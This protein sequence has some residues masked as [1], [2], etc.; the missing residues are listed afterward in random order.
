MLCI[1]HSNSFAEY[2][3]GKSYKINH[4]YLGCSYQTWFPGQFI[5]TDDEE[6]MYSWTKINTT[7]MLNCPNKLAPCHTNKVNKPYSFGFFPPDFFFIYH[8]IYLNS[9]WGKHVHLCNC[10]FGFNDHWRQM[11]MLN[12]IY[13]SLQFY[14]N[15]KNLTTIFYVIVAWIFDT[16]YFSHCFLHECK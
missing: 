10:Q 1:E 6:W 13:F 12:L 8:Q 4:H 14:N 5:L 15:I 9:H 16:P 3:F 7:T 2:L 11:C